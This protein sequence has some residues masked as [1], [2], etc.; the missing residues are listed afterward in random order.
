MEQF[1]GFL[2]QSLA[3][4]IPVVDPIGLVPIFLSLTVGIPLK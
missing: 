4:L 2:V 3:A 1:C